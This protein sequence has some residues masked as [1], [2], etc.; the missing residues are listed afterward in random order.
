MTFDE[1]KN[2]SRTAHSQ[3]NLN[4]LRQI[5]LNKAKRSDEKLSLKKEDL[6]QA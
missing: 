3:V 5:A 1:D 2:K 6:K 4:I